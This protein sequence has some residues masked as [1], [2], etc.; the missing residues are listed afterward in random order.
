MDTK[1]YSEFIM[2]SFYEDR[3]H[4]KNFS[5]NRYEI[6]YNGVLKRFIRK[7]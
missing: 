6:A 1:T 3:I 5:N 7:E 2:K 4:L